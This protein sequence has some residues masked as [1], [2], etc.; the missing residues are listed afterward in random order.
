MI[1]TFSAG[2]TNFGTLGELLAA[3]GL[4]VFVVVSVFA[5]STSVGVND[6]PALICPPNVST[7][8]ITVLS[9][10]YVNLFILVF[11]LPKPFLDQG[12][13]TT[14]L[15]LNWIFHQVSLRQSVFPI[16]R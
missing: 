6:A 1:E 5:N 12:K 16:C 10:R 2:K 3:T 7:N 15:A 9:N 8:N 4:S 13:Q 11:L 14:S